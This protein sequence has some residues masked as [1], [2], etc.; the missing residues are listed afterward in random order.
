MSAQNDDNEQVFITERR[1]LRAIFLETLEL[2]DFPLDVQVQFFVYSEI[3]H[4][5]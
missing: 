4:R 2:N 1:R 5:V 3:S